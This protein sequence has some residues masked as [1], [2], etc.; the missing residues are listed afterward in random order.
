MKEL[1]F[2][3][4]VYR[5]TSLIPKGKVSTYSAVSLAL[6]KKQAFRAVGKALNKNPSAPQVPCHR[7]I[8]ANGEVGGFAQGNR[9][10]IALLK[11]EGIII[12][13]GRIDLKQYFYGFGSK[14]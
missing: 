7:I 8:R 3:Q 11:K 13:K 4:K 5:L 10:K 1:S 9:R 12:K 6:H 2:P 14:K